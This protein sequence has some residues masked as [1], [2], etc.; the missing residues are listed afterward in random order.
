MCLVSRMR[1]PGDFYGRHVSGMCTRCLLFARPVV[2]RFVPSVITSH[3]AVHSATV[4]TQQPLWGLDALRRAMRTRSPTTRQQPTTR[5]SRSALPYLSVVRCSESLDTYFQSRPSGPCGY[6]SYVSDC[7]S[8]SPCTQ[9]VCMAAPVWARSKVI[10][11][12]RSQFISRP[13]RP[14]HM[15]HGAHRGP[16]SRDPS[17]DV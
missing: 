4:G 2:P 17:K 8:S 14:Y 6:V 9:R 7:P 1:S 3:P 10:S 11:L 5:V 13:Y 15:K 16:H 12:L